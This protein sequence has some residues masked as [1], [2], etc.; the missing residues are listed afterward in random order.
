VNEHLKMIRDFR[1]CHLARSDYATQKVLA[2]TRR[3]PLRL[4]YI[5]TEHFEFRLLVKFAR[6]ESVAGRVLCK[7]QLNIRQ[8]VRSNKW[9]K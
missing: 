3:H 8:S 9:N 7:M 4:L 1:I 2:L 6:P 5:I